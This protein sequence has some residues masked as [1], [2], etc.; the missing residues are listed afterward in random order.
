[1]ILPIE[2]HTDLTLEQQDKRG[3]PYPASYGLETQSYLGQRPAATLG[4]KHNKR[5][6]TRIW[7]AGVWNPSAVLSVNF[8]QYNKELQELY[9][10]YPVLRYDEDVNQAIR[11]VASQ[12]VNAL[13][14]AGLADESAPV[15]SR[16]FITRKYIGFAK[17]KEHE[18]THDAEVEPA[19]FIYFFTDGYFPSMYESLGVYGFAEDVWDDPDYRIPDDPDEIYSRLMVDWYS[20]K[21][22]VELTIDDHCNIKR[23][24]DRYIDEITGLF[25]P[26]ARME[27]RLF[28]LR[29]LMTPMVHPD[30]G[31]SSRK[32]LLQ[33]CSVDIMSMESSSLL[34]LR[35]GAKYS[36][37]PLAFK[38]S[39]SAPSMSSPGRLP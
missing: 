36:D 15:R 1:M 18:R 14:E 20:E 13:E 10:S 39:Q 35:R 6:V 12:L 9:E 34:D 27:A 19:D 22:G 33:H 32:Q 2:Y 5:V 21:L 23:N 25:S 7:R 30:E 31:E 17:L 28:G 29:A 16:L 24:A 26:G 8:N 4:D 3:P 11:K 37:L 38:F